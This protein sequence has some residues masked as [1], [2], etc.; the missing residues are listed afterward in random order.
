MST[1]NADFLNIVIIITSLIIAI[2]LPFKLFLFSYA[3]L[4]PLHYLTEINW[5]NKKQFF[6][7]KNLKKSYVGL[8]IAS[9]LILTIFPIYYFIVGDSIGSFLPLFEILNDHSNIIIIAL[10]L[11]SV[12]FFI[13]ESEK[14]ILIYSILV[15]LLSTTVFTFIS[16]AFILF[17]YLLSTI[18]HVYLFTLLFMIFGS[19]KSK[20]IFGWTAIILVIFVPI[21]LVFIPINYQSYNLTGATLVSFEKSKFLVLG[22]E[23]AGITGVL[24]NG[25]FYVLSEGGIKIQIFIAFAYTYHYLNWFSKTSIIGWGKAITKKMSFI[26]IT[27]WVISVSFY[28]ID[29]K[30]GLV[31][32]FFLSFLHVFSEYPLN[33]LTIKEL[34][35]FRKKIKS[36]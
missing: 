8:I 27:L 21:V 29:Y 4:G 20:S 6:L 15:I 32:L 30:L 31:A 18:I 36:L 9:S 33:V 11:I 17:A 1:K 23:I 7:N 19:I 16:K 3:V 14:A 28:M 35:S 22:K 5:L 24:K 13:F 34:F 12:G 26:I 10:F 25:I 2:I